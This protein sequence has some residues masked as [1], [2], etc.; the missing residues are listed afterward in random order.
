MRILIT[1]ASHG[2]G[3]KLAQHF[4]DS[5]HQVW[6]ISRSKPDFEKY[7]HWNHLS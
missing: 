3:Y 5:E 7:T 2:L 4:L 1:G 6:G